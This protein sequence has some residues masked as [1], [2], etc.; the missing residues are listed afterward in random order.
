MKESIAPILLIYVY[1][2]NIYIFKSITLY[3]HSEILSLPTLL[4]TNV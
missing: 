1:Y 2:I 4:N 3:S